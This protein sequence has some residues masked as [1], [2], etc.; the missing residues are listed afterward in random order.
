MQAF[1]FWELVYISQVFQGRRKTIFEEIDRKGGSTWSQILGVCLGTLNGV[2]TRITQYLTPASAPAEAAKSQEDPG[3]PRLAAPLKE[4]NIWSASLPPKSRGASITQTVGAIAKTHGQ[5]PSAP[6]AR[7]FVEQASAALPVEARE[8]LTPAGIWSFLTPY[9]TQILQSPMGWPF[10]QEYRR[11]IAAVV[12]GSPYGDAG[13]I[14]DAIDSLTRLAV[15]SLKED[16]YGNVQRDIP[17][18]I[19]TFTTTVSKLESFRQDLGTHWTDIEKKQESPETD[20]IVAALKG[21]LHE[22]LAAFGDYSEDLRLSQRDM[23]EAREAA[24]PTTSKK[25]EMKEK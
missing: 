5:S 16:P 2:N 20:T 8:L 12:L 24:T 13:M 3:L 1:A 9:A 17:T 4:D 21:G 19:R 23:R 14:V 25:I 18:I 11:R 6:P 10:R 22:L 7:K 15:S